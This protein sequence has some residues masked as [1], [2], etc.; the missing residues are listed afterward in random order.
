MRADVVETEGTRCAVDAR[1][2]RWI[3]LEQLDKETPEFKQTVIKFLDDLVSHYVFDEEGSSLRR[4][5][6]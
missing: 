6:A 1:I 4:T 5:P 2:G 3:P